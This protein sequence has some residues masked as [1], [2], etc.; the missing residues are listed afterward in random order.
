MKKLQQILN[1]KVTSTTLALNQE[2]NDI[3]KKAYNKTL[4]FVKKK[5]HSNE[6][7]DYDNDEMI[8]D[9]RKLVEKVKKTTIEIKN[10]AI[11]VVN[12]FEAIINNDVTKDKE[13]SLFL[14]FKL[15]RQNANVKKNQIITICNKY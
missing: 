2:I 13:I 14:R 5:F 10:N 15:Q 8:N 7:Y 9:L 6:K 11:K 1:E 12:I 4:Y 3:I